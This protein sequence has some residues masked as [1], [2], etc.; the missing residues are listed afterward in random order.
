LGQ[1]YSSRYNPWVGATFAFAKVVALGR[2]AR[3]W[4]VTG[5]LSLLTTA[6][7]RAKRQNHISFA[8][9]KVDKRMARKTARPDIW[10]YVTKNMD[11]EGGELAP[12]ELHSNGAVFMLAGTEVRS[13]MYESTTTQVLTAHFNVRRQPQRCFQA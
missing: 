4:G 5:M 8:A 9:E 6:E 7:M 13:S 11:V 12:S 1:L 2:I 3:E 10:K